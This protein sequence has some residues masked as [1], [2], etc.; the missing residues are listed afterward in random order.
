[1]TV[2]KKQKSFWLSQKSQLNY[3]E[4]IL[5]MQITYHP[6]KRACI[7]YRLSLL[8]FDNS[9]IFTFDAFVNKLLSTV[10]LR[11]FIVYIHINVIVK[12]L[13]WSGMRVNVQGFFGRS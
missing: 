3:D 4:T 13:E 10:H 7:F 11:Y 2:R 6:Y 12:S 9:H 8:V 5:L 1:M